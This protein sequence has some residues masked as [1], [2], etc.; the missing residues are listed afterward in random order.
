[1]SKGL[2]LKVGGNIESTV[3]TVRET[4]LGPRL[5]TCEPYSGPYAWQQCYWQGAVC[6]AAGRPC[7]F[8]YFVAIHKL[9]NEF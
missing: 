7:L 6:A 8:C 3:L 2:C 9:L 4:G 5:S 1:M